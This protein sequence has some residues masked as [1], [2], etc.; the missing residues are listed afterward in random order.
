MGSQSFPFPCTP[1]ACSKPSFE[2][3]VPLRPH[4]RRKRKRIVTTRLY[5]QYD[6]FTS[7]A[8]GRTRSIGQCRRATSDSASPCR[9]GFPS[10]SSPFRR[11]R[12]NCSVA[13]STTGRCA[14][15]VRQCT[16]WSKCVDGEQA[17]SPPTWRP[18]FVEPGR[19][20]SA[21]SLDYCR[22]Y[23]PT[24]ALFTTNWCILLQGREL[25]F[26]ITTSISWRRWARAT[27]CFTCIMLYTEVEA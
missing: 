25:N 12:S 9:Y 13:R 11:P 5:C 17:T 24:H 23:V 21:P 15:T 27:R 1:L 8:V 2:I 19:R 7:N 4:G 22:H 20:D 16:P 18:S 26:W 3:A 10:A 6:T 14:P